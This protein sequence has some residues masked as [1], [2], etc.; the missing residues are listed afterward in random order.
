VLSRCL[1]LNFAGESGPRLDPNC[2][3]W[4][5]SFSQMA[6][7]QQNGLLSRY[8]LLGSLLAKLNEIKAQTEKSLT[9]RSPLQR[10]EDIDPKLRERW[11][12]ELTGAREAEARRRRA[13]V[14]LALQWWLRDVWL[15]ALS[16]G[17]NLLSFPPLSAAATAVATRI[18]P[19]DALAN[20]EVL[21]ETQR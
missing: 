7:G 11:G 10:Y 14:L 15:H 20:I 6:G 17:H 13:D 4:V 1:R 21:E 5:T 9:A 8:R 16:F 12:D 3:E 2:E 18:S 19:T